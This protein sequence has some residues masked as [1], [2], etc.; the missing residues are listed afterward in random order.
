MTNRM[1]GLPAIA[2]AAILGVGRSAIAQDPAVSN[3]HVPSHHIQLT[4]S[5]RTTVELALHGAIRRLSSPGCQQVF[6]DFTDDTGRTLA[7]N[8]AA[9]GRT[10]M[11]LL[12][13]VFFVDADETLQCR[14][15]DGVAAFTVPG[16]RV[17]HVCAKRF[18]HFEPNTVNEEIVLIHELLHT[19][20][21]GENPPT[22]S[23][24]TKAVRNRCG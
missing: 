24:I 17:V 9:T 14:R 8:L 22:S 18:G 10:P 5:A 19:L 12:A 6:E 20:G 7:V 1:A 23:R 2:I 16:T 15:N 13:D 4:G 21:L 3:Q 11:R